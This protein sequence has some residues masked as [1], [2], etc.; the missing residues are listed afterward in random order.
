MAI[1]IEE[2]MDL[3]T[4]SLNDRLHVAM[5]DRT[6]NTLHDL[7]DYFGGITNNENLYFLFDRFI[8]ELEEDIRININ[9]SSFEEK[10]LSVQINALRQR[11]QPAI[12][13]CKFQINNDSKNDQIESSMN[14]L[15]KV[16][17]DIFIEITDMLN[18]MN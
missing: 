7:Y 9:Y 16:I 3:L 15:K 6:K 18:S 1:N 4:N 17:S 2:E 11:A 12:E 10:T 14:K 8:T 5:S 13:E